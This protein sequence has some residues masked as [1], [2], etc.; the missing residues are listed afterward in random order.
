MHRP[1]ALLPP[2]L[3]SLCSPGAPP[4]RRVETDLNFPALSCDHAFAAKLTYEV[5]RLGSCAAQQWYCDSM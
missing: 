5:R 4:C 1:L 2:H 3:A